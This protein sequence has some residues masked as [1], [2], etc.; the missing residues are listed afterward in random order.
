MIIETIADNFGMKVN[1]VDGENGKYNA[2]LIDADCEM[3][4]AAKC[5]YVSVEDA[6]VS[7][8]KMLNID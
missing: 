4:V 5:G 6:K 7:A 8:K 3:M 2:V 1:I